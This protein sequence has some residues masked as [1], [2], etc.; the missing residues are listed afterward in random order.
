MP[1]I[2]V[3]NLIIHSTFMQTVFNHYYLCRHTPKKTT[4]TRGNRENNSFYTPD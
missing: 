1:K 4:Q 2:E 3:S